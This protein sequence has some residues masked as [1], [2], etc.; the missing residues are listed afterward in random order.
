[1]QKDMRPSSSTVPVSL[2]PQNALHLLFGVVV[3]PL[4]QVVSANIV[5]S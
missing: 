3:T 4:Q 5:S 2:H 1:M